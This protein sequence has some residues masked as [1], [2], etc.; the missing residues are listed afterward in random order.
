MRRLSQLDGLRALAVAAV[1]WSHWAPHYNFGLPFGTGVQL[2]FVLS[3]F[4]ITAILL[5]QRA[6]VGSRWNV[7]KI[8]YARRSVRIFPAFYLVLALAALFGVTDVREKWTWHASYLS[9]FLFFNQ[10]SWGP[11]PQPIRHFW[12]LAVEEQFYLVWPFLVLLLPLRWLRNTIIFLILFAPA[13]RIAATFFWP[14]NPLPKVLPFACFDALGLGS[15]L[16]LLQRKP[17]MMP[18]SLDRFA[19]LLCACGLAGTILFKGLTAL[20]GDNL[21]IRSLGHTAW[22]F[23]FGWLIYRAAIGFD[24]KVGAFLSARPIVYIGTI[25]YGIYLFHNLIPWAFQHL[26]PPEAVTIFANHFWIALLAY[27]TTTLLIS[28]A[29]WHLLE[30]PFNSLKRYFPYPARDAISLPLPNTPIKPS[31]VP[32]SIS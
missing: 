10:A 24:G 13:F 15:L 18:I 11:F 28:A 17:E 6:T 31:P 8:F 14:D 21:A 29:S 25:S 5:E 30:L 26:L 9:N 20:P 23:F 19:R 27:S 3:G 4:L 22:I 7:W 1:V 2:F 32:V 12:S 16:A